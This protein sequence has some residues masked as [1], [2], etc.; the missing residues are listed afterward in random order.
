MSPGIEAAGY[1]VMHKNILGVA[2][3]DVGDRESDHAAA[4]FS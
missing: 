3:S 2:G 4:A 1:C